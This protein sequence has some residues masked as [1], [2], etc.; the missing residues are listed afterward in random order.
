MAETMSGQHAVSI[1][2]A[3]VG[4]VRNSVR[5]SQFVTCVTRNMY[6]VY[7]AGSDYVII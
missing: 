2:T 1:F 6:D 3:E 5:T 4:R 7:E